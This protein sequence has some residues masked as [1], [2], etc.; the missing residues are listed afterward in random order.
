MQ[1]GQHRQK[2]RKK[3]DEK[4]KT[5][6]RVSHSG[7]SVVM[8]ARTTELALINVC[9]V[10]VSMRPEQLN[11]RQRQ[12]DKGFFSEGAWDRNGSARHM[13]N[14]HSC[15]LHWIHSA[16]QQPALCQ[17]CQISFFK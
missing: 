9:M 13:C 14:Q 16:I 5:E 11:L 8:K 2:H 3:V 6:G 7:Y 4:G 17:H 15:L 1:P 12:T 10:V